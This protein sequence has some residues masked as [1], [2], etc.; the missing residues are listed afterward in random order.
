MRILLSCSF[1]TTFNISISTY[2]ALCCLTEVQVSTDLPLTLQGLQ[3]SV[4]CRY[5]EEHGTSRASSLPLHQHSPGEDT[6]WGVPGEEEERALPAEI[7]T[8]RATEY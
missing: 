7:R 8:V 1:R 4:H 2:S 6:D 3:L 5:P